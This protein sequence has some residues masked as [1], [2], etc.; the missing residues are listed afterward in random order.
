LVKL[1][2]QPVTMAPFLLAQRLALHGDRGDGCIVLVRKPGGPAT[3]PTSGW[4]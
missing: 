2:V 1:A 3:G 4:R